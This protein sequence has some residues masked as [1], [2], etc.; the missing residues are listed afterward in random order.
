M[1]TSVVCKDQLPWGGQAP[2]GCGSTGVGGRVR[3][4]HAAPGTEVRM[5]AHP[6]PIWLAIPA[7]DSAAGVSFA[8]FCESHN[9]FPSAN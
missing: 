5:L 1:G 2:W 8:A 3:A 6:L 7:L 4:A 9:T